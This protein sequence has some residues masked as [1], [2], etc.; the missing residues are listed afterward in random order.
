MKVDRSFTAGLPHDQ[1]S[2]KIVKAVAALAADM[3]L[4]CVVEG[5]ETAAQLAALP[6]GVHV[7]GFLTGRP[8]LPAATDLRQIVSEQANSTHTERRSIARTRVAPGGAEHR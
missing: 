2:R 3:G 1:T 6:V 5:V 4:T 7:Q 8:Q